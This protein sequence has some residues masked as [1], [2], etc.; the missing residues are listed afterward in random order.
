VCLVAGQ[1]GHERH[2]SFSLVPPI[3]RYNWGQHWDSPVSAIDP[4]SYNVI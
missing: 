1:T 2:L 3:L 4:E